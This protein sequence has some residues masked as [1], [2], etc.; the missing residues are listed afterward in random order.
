MLNKIENPDSEITL[1]PLPHQ[2][3]NSNEPDITIL[4]AYIILYHEHHNIKFLISG[5]IKMTLIFTGLWATA[6]SGGWGNF[7]YSSHSH[8]EPASYFSSNKSV[9]SSD[10][11]YGSLLQPSLD[12]PSLTRNYREEDGVWRP[13]RYWFPY[14]LA[15]LGMAV[16]SY[17]YIFERWTIVDSLYFAVATFTTV[18]YGDQEPTTVGGQAF[19]IVFAIYGILILGVFIGIFGHSVSEAQAQAV[20]NMKRKDQSRLLRLLFHD[21]NN[22]ATRGRKDDVRKLEE[23]FI[24]DHTSLFQVCV[25]VCREEFP[26]IALVMLFASILGYR[27]GWSITSTI[28]FAVMSAST[29]GFGN[30]APT[31]Q[32]DKIYCIFFFPI[33]VA[34]FGE[35]LG[36][37]AG[38]YIQQKYRTR[39][40]L[41]LKRSI[42]MCDLNRMD[43][44][45]DG[46][47]HLGD[48]LSF[49]LVALQKVDQESIDEL[50]A[51]FK[52]LDSNG[53][54]VLDKEDVVAI[55]EASPLH[56]I[57]MHLVEENTFDQGE[58]CPLHPPTCDADV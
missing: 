10:A 17:S 35:V 16:I 7:N 21:R 20:R 51:L 42:T 27:E 8:C 26:Q 5:F 24:T 19:T 33:S 38:T 37:I 52:S 13:L 15:Y 2:S 3:K 43:A 25:Q 28:Y 55:A 31:T 41:F 56:D 23:N 39:E 44:D 58:S 36:R 53:N 57:Q 14:L 30:Y 29:T 12:Q 49:M 50:K 22:S 40:Q 45:D 34:V 32:A 46:E 18:G 54:G 47:V 48:F 11:N 6:R 9:S 1:L 4:N